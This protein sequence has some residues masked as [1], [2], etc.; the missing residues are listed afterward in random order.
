MEF[1]HWSW[2]T[3]H[4]QRTLPIQNLLIW[5]NYYFWQ[6]C[7]LVLYLYEWFFW[8]KPLYNQIEFVWIYIVFSIHL[9]LH[10]FID[11]FIN[12]FNSIPSLN[13]AIF[14][15][16]NIRLNSL[17]FYF[18]FLIKALLNFSAFI[19]FLDLHRPN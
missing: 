12:L 18:L 1:Q 16:R 2:V 17:H 6:E 5:I 3:N 10:C 13:K 19:L 9:I 15:F 4:E 11:I 7:W 14:L 8:Y